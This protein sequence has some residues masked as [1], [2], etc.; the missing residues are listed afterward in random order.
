MH[1]NTEICYIKIFP[2]QNVIWSI[3]FQGRSR[4]DQWI[5]KAEN[6]QIGWLPEGNYLHFKK[7][8]KNYQIQRSYRP[9]WSGIE[10]PRQ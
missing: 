7:K 4:D 5:E 2:K 10:R 8:E 3:S 1:G 9:R 6:W